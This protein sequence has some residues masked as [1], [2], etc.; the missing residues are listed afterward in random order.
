MTS[1]YYDLQGNIFAADPD[2]QSDLIHTLNLNCSSAPQPAERKAALDVLVNDLDSVPPKALEDY[3][4][5]ALNGFLAETD[6]KTPYVGILIWYLQ[7]LLTALH[8]T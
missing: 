3:C 6:T 5:Q 2:V 1:I 4:T 7:S 8:G